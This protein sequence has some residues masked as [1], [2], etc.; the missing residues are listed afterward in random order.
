MT[1][2]LLEVGPLTQAFHWPKDTGTYADA[3]CA[4]GLAA[5]LAV[6]TDEDPGIMDCGTSFQITLSRDYDLGRL[7]YGTLVRSPGYGFV[8]LPKDVGS[9]WDFVEVLDYQEERRRED[10]QRKARA[11][12][13]KRDAEGEARAESEAPSPDLPLLK[14]L[15]T[16]QALAPASRF[17]VALHEAEPEV[18][19]ANVRA[20][21]ARLSG[22]RVDLPKPPWSE[23]TTALQPYRPVSGKGLNRPKMD[24][25]AVGNLQIPWYE[26]W[27]Q[28]AGMR[29]IGLGALISKDAK[30]L[31]VSPQKISFHDLRAVVLSLRSAPLS[32]TPVK[33]DI[34]A[35]IACLCSL[36]QLRLQMP[37]RD[38]ADAFWSGYVPARVIAGLDGA[39]FKSL[40]SARALSGLSHLNLPAWLRADSRAQAE[41]WSWAL[42][43]HRD[44]LRRL[45]EEHS[46]AAEVLR[47][48]RVFLSAPTPRA[49][50]TFTAAYGVYAFHARTREERIASWT[51]PDVERVVGVLG[52]DE[53]VALGGF[54]AAPGF[55]ALADAIRRATVTELYLKRDGRQR[56]EI[57]YALL[58]E[59]RRQARLPQRFLATLADFV[60]AY[61]AE[62][63]K[64]AGRAGKATSDAADEGARGRRSIAQGEL[65]SFLEAYWKLDRGQQETAGLLL[66]AFGSATSGRRTAES[67]GA[68]AALDAPEDSAPDDASAVGA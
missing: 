4:V 30:L 55:R 41:Q 37:D 10:A 27:F 68:P 5:V 42:T 34:L 60:A 23:Y 1:V 54:I 24:S 26:A 20:V 48:Y 63:A 47:H 57:H 58:T 64:L 15:H 11:A 21:L 35:A 28:Y 16:S 17:C 13:S 12:G 49:W 51:G 36:L 62:N 3:L 2:R 61:N 9:A 8:R 32:W 52:S 67:E 46:D 50:A 29:A 65:D 6:L 56:Y 53:S 39:Y 19:A 33:L 40:G 31:V 43:E 38:G 44:R 7:P 45:D 66:V 22:V 25:T 59:L 14:V 18:V